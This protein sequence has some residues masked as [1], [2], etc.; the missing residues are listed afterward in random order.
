MVIPANQDEIW[1]N[2]LTSNT[3][4]FIGNPVDAFDGNLTTRVRAGQADGGIL[5]LNLTGKGFT[6]GL[7][8]ASTNNRTVTITGGSGGTKTLGDTDGNGYWLDFSDHTGDIET[9]VIQDFTVLNGVGADGILYAV[10]INGAMLVD[11]GITFD[12]PAVTYSPTSSTITDVVAIASNSSTQIPNLGTA[13]ANYFRA[14]PTPYAGITGFNPSYEDAT[15]V[16]GEQNFVPDSSVASQARGPGA[17]IEF[18]FSI[19]TI[20][21]SSVVPPCTITVK[22]AD[23]INKIAVYVLDED[24]YAEFFDANNIQIGG[25]VY[26][27]NMGTYYQCSLSSADLIA[28]GYPIGSLIAFDRVRV[29]NSDTK[30]PSGSAHIS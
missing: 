29:T 28:A 20:S 14:D 27:V 12:A 9:I 1:S 25:K 2:S 6:G 21:N 24:C 7:R 23:E 5:T 26:P 8:V 22:S 3:G 18:A 30:T 19:C 10:E 13:P 11:P 15:K 4:T 17:W 16:F